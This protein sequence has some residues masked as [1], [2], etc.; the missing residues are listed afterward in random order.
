MIRFLSGASDA[1]Y[2]K[3]LIGG[4]GQT[5]NCFGKHRP[6]SGQKKSD[7]LSGANKSVTEKGRQDRQKPGNFLF[8]RKIFYHK[9]KI[10]KSI[11]FLSP[12]GAEKTKKLFYAQI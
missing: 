8:T 12:T 2:Q 7:K 9:F 11:L 1:D 5:M 10:F 6:R 3:R 4:I